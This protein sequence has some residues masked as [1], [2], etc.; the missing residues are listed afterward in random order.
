MARPPQTRAAAVLAKAEDLRAKADAA[1]TRRAYAADV[2]AYEAWCA[3][4]GFT[5]LPATPQVVG[6][7]LAACGEG[8]AMSTLRRRVAA[9]ARAPAR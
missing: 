7:Y 4:M 1:S 2:A 6:A 9:I 5:A 3:Q 8:Y